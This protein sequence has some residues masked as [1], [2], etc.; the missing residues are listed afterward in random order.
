MVEHVYYRT[1]TKILHSASASILCKIDVN[2]MSVYRKTYCVQNYILEKCV[3]VCV[4]IKIR[5]LHR[6]MFLAKIFETCKLSGG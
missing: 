4:L 5:S 2:V 1:K 3:C 6:F